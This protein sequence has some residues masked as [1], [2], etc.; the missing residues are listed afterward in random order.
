MGDV[1]PRKL[2]EMLP[3]FSYLTD[4]FALCVEVR[5]EPCKQ[6]S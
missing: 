5:F 4:V 6:G 3:H 1:M 2:Q